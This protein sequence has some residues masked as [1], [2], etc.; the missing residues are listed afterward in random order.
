MN[1]SAKIIATT[2]DETLA[3]IT[4]WSVATP[5][6]DFLKGLGLST[7]TFSNLAEPCPS[8]V[9]VGIGRGC[10]C[11]ILLCCFHQCH[12]DLCSMSWRR[13]AFHGFYGPFP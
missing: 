13:C 11:L 1:T 10:V 4:A 2:A 5:Q 12:A 9:R 8:T 7:T 6:R 3:H